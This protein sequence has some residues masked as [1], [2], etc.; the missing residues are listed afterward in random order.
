MSSA[1]PT[2]ARGVLLDGLPTLAARSRRRG[3]RAPLAGALVT[4]DGLVARALVAA[5]LRRRRSHCRRLIPSVSQG[6]RLDNDRARYSARVTIAVTANAPFL[7][8]LSRVSEEGLSDFASL[9]HAAGQ[10]FNSS[11]VAGVASPCRG[12]RKSHVAGVASPMSQVSQVP[13]R[14]CRKSHVVRP[15]SQVRSVKILTTSYP[16]PQ[17][18]LVGRHASAEICHG[19]RPSNNSADKPALVPQIRAHKTHPVL[20]QVR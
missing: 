7:R 10:D 19:C 18:L 5:F 6:C 9:G 12:C 20:V 14:R 1:G 15:M 16:Y 13:C 3:V 4:P 2:A 11:H 17:L 8:P